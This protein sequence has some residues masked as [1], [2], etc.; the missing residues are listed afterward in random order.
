MTGTPSATFEVHA[1]HCCYAVSTSWVWLVK[2]LKQRIHQVLLT[3]WPWPGS[4]MCVTRIS[5]PAIAFD[6]CSG[7]SSADA[8]SSTLPR[9]AMHLAQLSKKARISGWHTYSQNAAE[10][11]NVTMAE[12]VAVNSN[13]HAYALSRV[14]LNVLH[15]TPHLLHGVLLQHRGSRMQQATPV[16]ALHSS[17]GPQSAVTRNSLECKALGFTHL[18][19]NTVAI[20]DKTK[21]YCSA[22]D[23]TKVQ[24]RLCH[25]SEGR[26]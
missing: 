22:G 20:A 24:R 2:F 25:S 4:A 8:V 7:S 23:I 14:Y 13:T 17:L 12:C 11:C 9:T 19:C 26:L 5:Q 16:D 21:P 10:Q 6:I 15:E 1:I 18:I 3:S